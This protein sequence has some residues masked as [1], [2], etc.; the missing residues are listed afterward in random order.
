LTFVIETPVRFPETFAPALHLKDMMMTLLQK[1]QPALLPHQ[2]ELA[3]S[4]STLVE[5]VRAG[6]PIGFEL[7]MRRYNQRLYRLARGIVKNGSEA[8]DV[9][10]EAYVRAYEKLNDFIGPDG[11]SAWLGKIVVNEALG[12]LRKRGRVISLDDYVKGGKEG[13]DV[14]HID[15]MKTQQPDPERLA[16]SSELRR[17]LEQAIEALPDDFRNVFILRAVEGM[18]V[19]ETAQCL[20]IRAETVKTRLHRARRLLQSTLGAQF[21][22]LMPSTFVLGGQHCDRI[23]AAVLGRLGSSLGPASQPSEPTDPLLT[24]KADLTSSE[25]LERS[26]KC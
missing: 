13:A 26:T 15:T 14:R 16:A 23:V 20:S 10:Q 8:E 5:R 7:I 1:P 9:V 6:D 3:A 19:S 18:N 24:T 17:V 2:S 22:A 4:D 25:T 11:F 21:D 12:R